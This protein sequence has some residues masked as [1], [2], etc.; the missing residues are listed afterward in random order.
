MSLHEAMMRRCF[1]LARRA[2]G[3]AS[4]NP[5]VGCVVVKDGRVVG[6]GTHWGPGRVHAER[7]ALFKAGTKARGSTLYVNLEPCVHW[8]RTP[9]CAPLIV[10]AGV[11]RVFCSVGDPWYRIAGRGFTYL[12]SAGIE[13]QTGLLEREGTALNRAFLKWCTTGRPYVVVK[14]A[15]TM[16]GKLA[17][18]GKGRVWITSEESRA[19]AR[20]LRFLS[21]AI[22]VGANTVLLDDPQLTV[23]LKGFPE[24]R[25]VKVVLD[26]AG[27]ISP[28]ARLFEESPVVVFTGMNASERWMDEIRARGAIIIQE[29]LQNGKVPP[30]RILE[31]LAKIGTGRV[32]VE[33]G[34]DVISAFLERDLVDEAWL[35]IASCIF[36]TEGQAWTEGLNL[37][38]NRTGRITEVS[39]VG[40]DVKL[41]IQFG[42]NGQDNPY[43]CGNH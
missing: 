18:R 39:R 4:P 41:V 12:K 31:I 40:P 1:E 42:N 32:L 27:R 25:L 3:W 43:V 19:D 23:R 8:G 33:G 13:V 5:L 37:N 20:K 15:T 17:L 11:R 21:D 34:S 22:V 30:E 35:Y 2:E 38:K 24:K 16:D 36:G 6:E 7:E 9:P 10:Q 26:G 29:N 28:R 14:V